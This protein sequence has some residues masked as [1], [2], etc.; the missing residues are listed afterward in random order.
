MIKNS[1]N[2]LFFPL[3]P[4]NNRPVVD[5]LLITGDLYIDHPSFG[6][7]IITHLLESLGLTICVVSTPQYYDKSFLDTIPDVSLF[8]GITSGNLDSMVANYSSQRIERKINEYSIDN[9]VNFPNGL[10]IRPDLATIVYTSYF[11]SKYK[12]PIILGGIEASLRRLAHYD[13]ITQKLRRSILIDS[14]ADLIVYSMGE[15]AIVEIVNRLRNRENL[16]GINGTAI[17][18]NKNFLENT[19]FIKLNSIKLPSFREIL[20][21]K[22]LLIKATTIVEENFTFKNDK[23]LVQEQNENSFV[24]VYPPQ[25]PLSTEELDKIYSL[26]FK[27]EF[28]PYVNKIKAFEM[29]KNSITSHRGCFGGCSFCAIGLHQGKIIT[30]RSKES[31]REEIKKLTK[32]NYFRGTVSDIGGPTANMYG[33]KC[34]INTCKKISCLFPSIC[35]NLILD[36]ESYIKILE[37]A[38]N[39]DGVKNVFVSS[40]IRHDI[41]MLKKKETERIIIKHTSGRLKIAPEHIDEKILISMRKPSNQTLIDFIDFFESVKKENSLNFYIAAYII[42]SFHG[43]DDKSTKKLEQFLKKHNIKGK[44]YQDFTPT[45]MTLATAMFYSKKD[46]ND[47]FH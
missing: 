23:V 19:D 25:T 6:I 45:P 36:E 32:Q 42:L 18:T 27:K 3:S 46:I 26:P 39:I 7:A 35:E 5:V 37:E 24:V 2:I 40:G 13:F 4:S 8:I 11:K 29:I 28:P 34:K 1:E 41:A 38:K 33:S 47:N 14:K 12:V 44:H 22:Q 20:E 30:S 15:K 43:S 21:E 17:R 16:I 31:I 9:E 10:K